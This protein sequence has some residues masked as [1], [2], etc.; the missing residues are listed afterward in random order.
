M[1]EEKD[2]LMEKGE[3]GVEAEREGKNRWIGDGILTD[4]EE[5]KDNEGLERGRER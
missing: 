3:N 1:Q 4:G 2:M 5:E